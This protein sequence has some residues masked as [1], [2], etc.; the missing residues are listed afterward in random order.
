[1]MKLVCSRFIADFHLHFISS[2]RTNDKQVNNEADEQEA[3]VSNDCFESFE[4]TRNT[5]LTND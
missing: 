2:W 3:Q 5:T 1:M 4:R